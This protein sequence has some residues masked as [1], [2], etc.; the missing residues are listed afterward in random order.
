LKRFYINKTNY[1]KAYLVL[2]ILVLAAIVS[3]FDKRLEVLKWAAF[4]GIFGLSFVMFLYHISNLI[5]D[6]TLLEKDEQWG[7]WR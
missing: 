2:L 3:F 5:K 7:G 6:G 4:G 1:K